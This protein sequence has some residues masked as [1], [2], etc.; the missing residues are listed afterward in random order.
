MASYEPGEARS[1]AR[2]HLYGVINVIIPSFSADLKRINERAIRHDVRGQLE[3]GFDGALLV[4]E[5]A[6]SQREYRHFCEIAHDEAR[7]RQIFVHH[8]SWSTLAD[9]R[10]CVAHRR[11][12][13]RPL[14]PMS[15]W[16]R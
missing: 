8:S 11:P 4:S 9:Y 10:R 3:L 15:E 5:V 6:I 2:E 16:C 14:S 13:P 1:W 12:R 7:G